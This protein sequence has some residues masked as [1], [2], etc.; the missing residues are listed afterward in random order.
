MTRR[1]PILSLPG[2]AILVVLLTG[3][4][5]TLRWQGGLAFSP[6]SL[7]GSS[8]SEVQLGG[9]S[10]H[11]EF[12]AQ[13]ALCHQPITKLQAELCVVCH[14][15]VGHQIGSGS[16]FHGTLVNMQQCADCHSDHRG[17]DFD[18]RLGYLDHFD[19]SALA[20]SLI[21]HQVDYSMESIACLDCHV[22]DDE[23]SVPTQSCTTCH[24]GNDIKFMTA[25]LQDF[26]TD[27]TQCHDGQDRMTRF[28][29]AESDFPLTNSHLEVSCVE[30]HIQGQFE[31]LS[32]DCI[33]CHQEPYVH[34][35]TFTLDCES[36]H[37]SQSWKPAL[38]D[39]QL[40]DHFS[41]V[42]FSLAKH[43]RD[44]SGDIIT[45]D[46][47]H[48]NSV[49][50]FSPQTCIDCHAADDQEFINQ[51]QVQLGGNCL[52]C[53][54]G[55]DRMRAFDHADFFALDGKHNQIDCQ[56]CHVDQVYK[57]TLEECMDCHVEPEIHAGYF[58]LKCEYCHSTSSWYPA[59]LQSHQFPI[60]HGDQGAVAC[61]VCHVPTYSQY[62]CYGCHEHQEE[63]IIEEHREEGIVGEELLACF[64][65]HEDGSEH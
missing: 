20:F 5:L 63:E 12:E 44:Y 3:L 48:L 18:L 49:Q 8:R 25:H 1:S 46:S 37:N 61:Q 23:F 58:G 52:D 29:H 19:H 6:G 50:E 64:E 15:S 54:D 13:C 21:W 45:C 33:N 30:C 42:N 2:L 47:C 59:Q 51:H 9:F 40:F 26:G 43:S 39:G 53:H 7:S 65:C 41:Q 11:A 62:S 31:S 35:G 56:A 17:R 24:A 10:S 4:G 60:D 27:C 36:C 14:E 38:L 32:G 55:V 34:Q 22:S 28:N 16:G 57:G